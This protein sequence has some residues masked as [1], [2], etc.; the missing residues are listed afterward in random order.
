MKQQAQALDQGPPERR[1]HN[2]IVAEQGAN[3]RVRLRVVDQTEID[4][5]LH[6]RLI[7]LDQHTAGDHLYR[8]MIKAGYFMNCNWS[9][10][11]GTRGDVQSISSDKSTAL[12]KMGLSR[13]WLLAGIGRHSTE[14]LLGVVL[15][16]RSVSDKQVPLVRSGLNSYQGFDSWWQG[17]DVNV[18][19]P[20][21]LQD[22]PH[23]VKRIKPWAV[24]R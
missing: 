10:D 3:M 2:I 6:L 15:G 1:S 13:S 18:P 12:L 14:Y 16:E 7:S 8:D 22:L 11:S 5:L 19:V 21:L 24:G 9:L 4:R 17:R 20:E 23:K